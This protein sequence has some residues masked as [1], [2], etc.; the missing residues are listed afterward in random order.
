[1]TG[2]TDG[3]V[4]VRALCA[5]FAKGDLPGV[6]RA[7]S[8]DIDWTET[9]GFPYAG[10]DPGHP[11]VVNGAFARL[12]TEWDGYQAVA[13]SYVS[14]SAAAVALGHHSGTYKGPGK[15]FRAPFAHAWTISDGEIVRFV[16][17]ADIAVVRRALASD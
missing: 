10:N 9:K 8:P 3:E 11:A 17:Y 12:A 2:A 16:Q 6:L 14:A 4:L 13:G 7:L 15:S 5:G 1:M